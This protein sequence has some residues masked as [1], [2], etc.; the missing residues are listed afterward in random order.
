MSA[1]AVKPALQYRSARSFPR[2]AL[3]VPVDVTIFRSEIPESI[4]GRSLNLSEGGFAAALAGELPRAQLID[5][6]FTLPDLGLVVRTKAIVRHR[7]ALHYGMEFLE[8]SGEQR[9]MICYWLQHA[10]EFLGPQSRA[11][12][13]PPSTPAQKE[14]KGQ[15]KF[16]RRSLL[17]TAALAVLAVPVLWYWHQEWKRLEAQVPLQ[18]AENISAL[19]VAPEIMQQFLIHKVEPIYPDSARQANLEGIVT[20]SAVIGENGTITDL[21]TV[22][23][24]DVFAQAAL[25]AVRWWRF[26]PY[27]VHGQSVRVETTITVQFQR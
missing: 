6:Q 22:K 16:W 12:Q 23:G 5:V 1:A 19:A 14:K 21:K 9:A 8:L 25:D 20:L 27:R 2:L 15:G 24:A 11:E 18:R 3:K 7:S 13:L 10:P 26:E 4:P 17:A